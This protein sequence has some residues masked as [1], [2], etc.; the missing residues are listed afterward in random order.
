M[1]LFCFYPK[2]APL[3]HRRQGVTLKMHRAAATSAEA[4]AELSKTLLYPSSAASFPDASS[5]V[6][7]EPKQENPYTALE[8]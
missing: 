1:N 4:G 7:P 3:S 2:E 6:S 8:Q 5:C